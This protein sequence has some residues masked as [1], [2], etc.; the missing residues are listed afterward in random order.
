MLRVNSEKGVAML[1]QPGTFRFWF[2][3]DFQPHLKLVGVHVRLGSR[4]V[5]PRREHHRSQKRPTVYPVIEVRRLLA[6][7]KNSIQI[8][9]WQL[10]IDTGDVVLNA[11]LFPIAYWLSRSGQ[12][13]MINNEGR[14]VVILHA[15]IWVYKLLLAF[16]LFSFTKKHPVWK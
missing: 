1:H 7:I 14:V 11:R 16:L 13:W 6:R 9:R 12:L 3:S 8:T 2:K 15:R 5:K 4:A 10:D